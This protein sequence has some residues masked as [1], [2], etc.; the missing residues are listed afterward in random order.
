M[1]RKSSLVS[2]LFLGALPM[3][4]VAADPAQA[5]AGSAA[6]QSAPAAPGAAAAKEVPSPLFTQ[7]D[8]NHDGF[9]TKEEAKRSAE[10]TARFSK[11]D[12]DRDG[13]IAASEFK[14]GMEP[15]L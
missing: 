13:K 7:L 10:V 12:A 3:A 1:K 2:L 6:T 11:L 14:N 4:A 8:T 5:P 9:V 15:K